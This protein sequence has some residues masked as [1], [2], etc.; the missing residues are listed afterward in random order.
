MVS[1]KGTPP[2]PLRPKTTSTPDLS[3]PP[4][5]FSPRSSPPDV[6]SPSP[7]RPTGPLSW[8]SSL[9]AG[10]FP[11]PSSLFPLPPA[12]PHGLQPV[13]EAMQSAGSL[14]KPLIPLLPP[15]FNN[16]LI[17]DL[18]GTHPAPS[19]LDPWHRA[20]ARN[21]AHATAACAACSISISCCSCRSLRFTPGP[22]PMSPLAPQERRSRSASPALFQHDGSRPI[23]RPLFRSDV[24][25]G[26]SPPPSPPHGDEYDDDA[27]CQ[28]LAEADTCDNS[29]CPGG[30]DAPARY[31]ITVEVFD[32][33]AEEFYDRS[34]R[35]CAAC[36]RACKKSFL[37]NRIKS[38]HFDNSVRDKAMAKQDK[39]TTQPSHS[40]CPPTPSRTT[41]D[42][43]IATSIIE[44]S[45]A[46][47]PSTTHHPSLNVVTMLQ[48]AL[49]MLNTRPPT[50]A[51]FVATIRAAPSAS[52][53]VNV[54]GYSPPQSLTTY[55]VWAAS[56]S[57]LFAASQPFA[58]APARR[59]YGGAGSNSTSSPEPDIWTPSPRSSPDEI[60]DLTARANVPLPV[61]RPE[62]DASHAPS[63]ASSVDEPVNVAAT[64]LPT[65]DYSA[66]PSESI[67]GFLHPSFPERAI[68][69]EKTNGISSVAGTSR[70][71]PLSY[72]RDESS[73]KRLIG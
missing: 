28:A 58:A 3:P 11:T 48:D 17:T 55:P 56:T 27:Y 52:C 19:P 29:S 31:T 12:A 63:R 23:S 44:R 47:G 37:G 57:P 5:P 16:A 10:L 34:Y 36:N 35:A 60:D 24:G 72:M 38:R 13:S 61:S 30:S 62:S 40:P 4:P 66:L 21:C 41:G 45:N 9:S 71:H 39:D 53:V 15:L 54:S 7:L 33:G 73:P 68:L 22:P 20:H 6:T 51:G 26:P 32:D 25:N 70:S 2:G 65:P 64:P 49:H 14:S 59:F 67:D 46:P 18:A 42:E 8:A 69:D 43:P 50:P 1:D